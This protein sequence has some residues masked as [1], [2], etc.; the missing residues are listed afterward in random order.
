MENVS[1][2]NKPKDIVDLCKSNSNMSDSISAPSIS[3]ERNV[4]QQKP[5]KKVRKKDERL[6]E[7]ILAK[8]KES[9]QEKKFA[10]FAKKPNAK[11]KRKRSSVKRYSKASSSDG[12]H[13]SDENSVDTDGEM[14]MR[15]V[16][17][18]QFLVTDMDNNIV[19]KVCAV[20]MCVCCMLVIVC[21]DC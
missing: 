4:L 3:E 16:D 5:K 15:N 19:D 20:T 13:D 10:P 11:R 2:N 14:M 1:D 17:L 6:S 7:G 9:K 8:K 12:D 21:V 18:R